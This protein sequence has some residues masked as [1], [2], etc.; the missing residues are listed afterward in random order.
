MLAFGRG[1]GPMNDRLAEVESRLAVVERRLRELEARARVAREGT[2]PVP[3][4]RLREGALSN[5]ATYL[6]RVLLIFGGAYLLR[7]ITDYG[8]LPTR[9][10]I[11]TGAAY[12]LLWLYMAWRAA[13]HPQG[14][15]AARVYGAVSIFLALPI[16]VEA[17]TRFELL[18]G[19]QSAMALTAC[20]TL[21]LL[22]AAL[23]D[24]RSLAWLAVA[25]GLLTAAVLS[26]A[27]GAALAFA[28]FMLALGF[29][30]LW[31]VYLRHWRGLQWLGAAGANLGVVTLV[32]LSN[33]AHWTIEPLA[34]YLL[35]LLLWCGYLL[36]F[37]A[38]SH[39]QGH[40]PGVFEP[41][42]AM[43]SSAVACVVA[44]YM[45]QSGHA[46]LAAFGALAL[47]LGLGAYGL[48]FTPATRAARGTGYYFYATL[49]LALIVAGS[50][51][52]FSP[53]RAAV[54][55]ALAAVIL[56]WSSGRHDRVSLSLHCTLLLIAACA[57]SGV[58]GTGLHAFAGDAAAPWPDL[59]AAEVLVAFATVACLFIPV[60]QRSE[61]WG[62]LAVLPQLI[63]LLLAGWSVG[64]LV[65]AALAPAVAGVP[66]T[67][68]DPGTLA[69]LRTTVLSVAAV[70]LALSSRFPRWPEARWLAYP[71]LIAVGIKLA[72][73]DFPSGRPLTLFIAL[74]LV[75]GALILVSRLLPRR[76][77]QV[78]GP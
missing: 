59:A 76:T 39:L 1:V 21:Y 24:L 50:A 34:A 2:E 9:A 14:H 68:A 40:A 67:G 31:I 3:V 26:K 5:A 18:S 20:C 7:A 63:V 25:G 48:A 41:A 75:G 65:V 27:S 49:G 77:A 72:I 61:R 47:V 29:A 37:A 11:P 70:A 10:G 33:N 15:A 64:G 13:G 42:Q 57:G 4:E 54:A 73:E 6:G 23:R 51:L 36:S 58:L 43:I 74:A 55:W 62:P 44:I 66:G 45:A 71:V 56:A 16:L 8:F 22:V 52:L 35:A 19:A 53:A 78:T 60:A 69:A 12:A 46:G 17:V 32:A 38:R 28:V 30:T